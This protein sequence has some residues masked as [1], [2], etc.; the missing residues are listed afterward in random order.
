[1]AVHCGL[2]PVAGRLFLN[3]GGCQAAILDRVLLEDIHCARHRPDLVGIRT[4]RYFYVVITAREPRHSGRHA[5]NGMHDPT[6]DQNGQ[7]DAGHGGDACHDGLKPHSP[8]SA[9]L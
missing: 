1:M 9:G 5:G 7:N 2:A 3:L 8:V 6:T 4:R